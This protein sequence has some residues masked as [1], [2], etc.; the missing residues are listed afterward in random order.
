MDLQH[1]CT[2]AE[3][4]PR[5]K[6][7]RDEVAK[8]VL[9]FK[10]HKD[11]MSQRDF[12]R[13]HDIPRTTLQHWLSRQARM[14]ASP[15]AIAFFESPAGVAFLHRLCVASHLVMTLMNPCGIEQVGTLLDLAGLEDFIATSYSAHYRYSKELLGALHEYDDEQRVK[16]VK[17]LREKLKS[18]GEE[19]KSIILL[20]DETFHPE[21]C[22][23]AIHT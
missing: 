5:K 14:S 11:V 1:T 21:T 12:A 7:G 20:E 18:E 6:W 8:K 16:L 4:Q 9:Q 2:D 15:E 10:E 17:L 3:K 13:R 22:L 19:S 23:V